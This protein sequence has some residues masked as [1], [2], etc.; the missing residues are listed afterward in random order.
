MAPVIIKA[1]NTAPAKLLPHCIQQNC[2]YQ[3]AQRQNS[4]I[5]NKGVSASRIAREQN[6]PI[7][8]LMIRYEILIKKG[9]RP[10]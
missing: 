10:L 2:S 7:F 8:F 1:E 4:G 6:T 5:C 3:L 9:K